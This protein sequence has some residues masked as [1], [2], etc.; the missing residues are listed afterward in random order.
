VFISRKRSFHEGDEAAG[1][2]LQFVEQAGE[3]VGG[4]QADVLGEH[5]EQAAGEEVGHHF[6]LVPGFLERF[7][8]FGQVGGDFAGDLSAAFGGVEG[9]GVGPYRAQAFADLV[10]GQVIQLDAVGGGSGKA[11]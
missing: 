11:R 2:A 7:G 3:A 4:Q 6:G 8:E 9:G 10:L 1:V 5:A